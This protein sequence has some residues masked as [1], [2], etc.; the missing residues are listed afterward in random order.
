MTNQGPRYRRILI[1]ADN[2]LSA[3]L[4]SDTFVANTYDAFATSDIDDAVRLATTHNPGSILLMLSALDA[5]CDA[6]QQFRQHT[7]TKII[8][9]FK[10]A[11]YRSGVRR[12]KRVRRL[13]LWLHRNERE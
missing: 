11:C 6:A 3:K 5:T 8:A 9:F 4:L 7:Y 13:S 12:A 10:N 2:D 1:V